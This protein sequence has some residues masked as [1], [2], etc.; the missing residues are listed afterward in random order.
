MNIL[1]GRCTTPVTVIR[2][3]IIGRSG[4]G[5]D[6]LVRSGTSARRIYKKILRLIQ[7]RIDNCAIGMCQLCHEN[8][9]VIS[10][11]QNDMC[12]IL[13]FIAFN[14]RDNGRTLRAIIR[15]LQ[16]INHVP[17][18]IGCKR[19]PI[20]ECD[21]FTQRNRYRQTVFGIFRHIC[22]QQRFIGCAIV[23]AAIQRFKDLPRHKCGCSVVCLQR[24]H[25]NRC[26][27]QFDVNGVGG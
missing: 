18:G 3:Q 10:K 7:S 24:V 23:R 5:A 17:D 14:R 8:A 1:Y 22:C 11:M 6:I 20:L 15:I 27:C 16:A 19:C 12:I 13:N 2:R 9:I 21:A 26:R 4:N 25:A